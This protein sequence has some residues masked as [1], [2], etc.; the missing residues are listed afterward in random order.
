MGTAEGLSLIF[1]M[2]IPHI[3]LSMPAITVEKAG[4][5]AWATILMGSAVDLISLSLLALI[6]KKIPGDLVAMSEQLLGKAAAKIIC[7]YYLIM[8]FSLA[9]FWIREFAENTLLTALPSINFHVAII[10][11]GLS[12][13]VIIYAG[14]EAICRGTYLLLSFI[15]GGLT[16]VLI[17]VYPFYEVNDLFPWQGYG[18]DRFFL[19]SI[20][21]IGGNA[22]AIAIAIF[23]PS[24]QTMRNLNMSAVFGLGI[25]SVLK[26]LTIIV[27]IM[28]FGT[29]VTS[30]KTLPFFEIARLV[31]FSRY[32]QRIESLFI[33]L[34]VI[35]GML[36][37]AV[38][39]FTCL[40]LIARLADLPT[41]RP[42]ILAVTLI[43]MMI[44][45]LP[46]DLIT[47]NIL[48]IYMYS[49]YYTFGIILIPFSLFVAFLIK[50]R[51]KKKCTYAQ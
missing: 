22:G 6:F 32:I 38:S 31:Y 48:E 36:A 4:C 28:V 43:A 46:P 45:I 37:I 7:F 34:L 41:I 10:W 21:V 50:C 14:I 2:T 26:S 23:A 40:Y 49:F 29:K 13:A 8:F 51:R 12:A 17:A 47:V 25:S 44:A 19:Q 1:I 39:I 16:I 3:F 9:V 15:V 11:Y 30:E 5:I 24:F 20:V 42:L 27:L 35:V 18:L 33:V